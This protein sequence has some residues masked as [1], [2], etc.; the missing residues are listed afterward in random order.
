MDAT[1]RAEYRQRLAAELAGLDAED[2]LGAEG[3]KTVT[4]DQSAVGRLSRLDALQ[5]QAMA[6]AT[7]TRRAQR[8]RRIAAALS[9][10]DDGDFGESV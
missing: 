2:A 9:R 7:S 10:M 6:R 1:K 5:A 8:R 4:L 3:R